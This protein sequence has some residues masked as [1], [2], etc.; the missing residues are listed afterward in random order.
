MFNQL[1]S[2][3][4]RRSYQ[5]LCDLDTS[6]E[7][8]SE[9]F[10]KAG[11]IVYRWAR[12]KFRYIFKNMPKEKSTLDDRRDANEIGVIDDRNEGRFVLRAVHPDGQVAGRFWMTDVQ[13]N[14]KENHCTMAIRLSVSSLNHCEEE[15]PFSQPRF[16]K[17][18]FKKIGIRDVQRVVNQPRTIDG[19]DAVD[20]FVSLLENEK[21]HL[22]IV[23]FSACNW[24]TEEQYEGYMMNP[25]QMAKDLVGVAHIFQITQEAVDDLT[26]KIGRQWSVYNGAVRTYYAGLSLENEDYYRHPL[27]TQ[28]SIRLKNSISEDGTDLCMLDIE[29]HIKNY[30]MGRWI[31]WEEAGFDFYS[32]LRQQYLQIQ[33]DEG[34]QTKNE[35]IRSYEQQLEEARSDIECYKSIANSYLGD[36]EQLKA[37][38]EEK[39]ETIARLKAKIFALED[40]LKS[41][42]EDVAASIPEQPTYEE[43]PEW[44]QENF[45]D[46]V[47]LHSRALHSLKGA[48][49]EDITLVYRCVE[50]L[51][52]S[53][54]DFRMGKIQHEEFME[55]CKATDA[56][57]DERGAITDTSAGMQ[58]DTYF[59][60]Y[61]G[62]KRKLERHLTKGNSKDQRYCM[63]IYFFWDDDEQIVVIGDLPRHLDTTAT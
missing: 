42:K 17:D 5:L 40:R 53:Y 44:I 38:N 16:V 57:I 61:R 21:R 15:V 23:L 7:S 34:S 48:I 59:V 8:A 4:M 14:Q 58:G 43:L 1:C 36:N 28:K 27:I 51:A 62:K 13:I 41:K 20:S 63:R 54:Y 60:Q 11:D 29:E 52:T 46:R 24:P 9:A 39:S 47:R 18:I 6:T 45:P 33:R 49:Y 2:S 30:N 37:D 56:G 35:R 31:A 32:S 12:T 22:P 55:I 50:L 25:A 26:N 3:Y 10:E 19:P